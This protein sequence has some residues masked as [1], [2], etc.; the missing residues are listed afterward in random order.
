MSSLRRHALLHSP[1][2][3]T[4]KLA[5]PGLSNGRQDIAATSNTLAP[6]SFLQ[7]DVVPLLLSFG[8]VSL[9]TALLLLLE[10]TVATSLVPIAYLVPVIIAATRW[11]ILA[12]DACLHR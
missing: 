9:V 2:P 5:K 12:G 3:I 11:G 8:S 1:L 4:S 7:T 10:Q 6:R